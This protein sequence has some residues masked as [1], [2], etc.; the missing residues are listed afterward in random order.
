MNPIG[1][2]IPVIYLLIH[3]V[4]TSEQKVSEAE[5]VGHAL[6]HYDGWNTTISVSRRELDL[7][8]AA[9]RPVWD[10]SSIPANGI[11]LTKNTKK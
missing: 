9:G 1:Q 11:S 4:G 6:E 3:L 2:T 5:N 7:S 10:V 8:A